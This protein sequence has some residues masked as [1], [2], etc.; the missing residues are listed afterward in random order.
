MI[1]SNKISAIGSTLACF[2]LLTGCG[3]NSR[4]TSDTDHSNSQLS[5]SASD[6]GPAE[7]SVASGDLKKIE[8][9]LTLARDILPGSFDACEVTFRFKNGS[10]K[11][12]KMIA[13]S[14]SAVGTDGKAVAAGQLPV[15]N[16]RG[17]GTA[18]GTTNLSGTPC[19]AI[20]KLTDLKIDAISDAD[21]IDSQPAIGTD[22]VLPM[23]PA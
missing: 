2:L 1:S 9:T 22:S 17:D 21:T 14:F 5:E 19:S 13:L 11:L 12:L 7:Q 16:L 15:S 20:A 18:T 3:Q 8:V 4:S 6:T 10:D 23:T